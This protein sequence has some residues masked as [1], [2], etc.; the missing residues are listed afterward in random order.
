MYLLKKYCNI[1]V[2]FPLLKTKDLSPSSIDD[3]KELSTLSSDITD[4]AD[5]QFALAQWSSVHLN[6]QPIRFEQF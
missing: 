2:L 3:D 4:I 6:C 1:V 5:T